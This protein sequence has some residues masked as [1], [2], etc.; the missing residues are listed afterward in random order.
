M[1]KQDLGN[2]LDIVK[3]PSL[4]PSIL[5]ASSKRYEVVHCPDER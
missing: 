4:I 3:H 2:K 1:K 5:P